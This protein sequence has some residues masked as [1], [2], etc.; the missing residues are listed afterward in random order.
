MASEGSFLTEEMRQEAIGVSSEPTVLEVEKGAI[1]RFAEAIGDPNPLWN[2]EADAGRSRYGGLIAPP[3]FLRSAG[4]TRPPLPFEIPYERRL[5]GG[6]EWEY[7][8]PLRV[9]D[10]ITIVARIVDVSERTGKI[11]TMLFTVAEVTYTNQFDQLVA[12]QRNT[13]ITY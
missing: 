7:F 10:H 12:I 13:G 4:I 8:E 5:D 3:T 6:S 11:G 1:R 2:D 9:G